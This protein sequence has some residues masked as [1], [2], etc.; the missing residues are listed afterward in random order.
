MPRDYSSSRSDRGRRHRSRD[1]HDRYRDESR[2]RSRYSRSYRRRDR[3]RDRSR[4]RRRRDDIHERRS[5][6]TVVAIVPIVLGDPATETAETNPVVDPASAAIVMTVRSVT[7]VLGAV[8][9]ARVEAALLKK[10]ALVGLRV[11]PGEP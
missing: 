1:R 9:A 6:H 5:R 7:A 11:S 8:T 10:I 2:S 4:E 3:S